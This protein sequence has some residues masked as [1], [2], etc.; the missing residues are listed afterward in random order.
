MDREELKQQARRMAMHLDALHNFISSL[1][2]YAED[3]VRENDT[4]QLRRHLEDTELHLT[5]FK[6]RAL[7][8]EAE[9]VDL[10]LQLKESERLRLLSNDQLEMLQQELSSLRELNRMLEVRAEE[11]EHRSAA[12]EAQLES[13]RRQVE[14]ANQRADEAEE[15]AISVYRNVTEKL[16]RLQA[17]KPD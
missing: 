1:S 12:A 10:K 2:N 4:G 6:N 16:R 5:Q 9:V 15:R 7:A 3:I 11:S 8:A 17:K 14:E 13:L